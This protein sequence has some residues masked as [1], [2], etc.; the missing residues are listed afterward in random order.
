MSTFTL[1]ISFLTTFNLPWFMDQ[2]LHSRFLCNIALESIRLYFHHQS[3]LQLGIVFALVPSL[4]FFLELFLH[5]YPVPYRALTDLGI[6]S[7]SVL[8]FHLFILFMG[9][10]WQEYRSGLPFPSPVDH[11][12]SELSTTIH[13]YWVVIICL[14]NAC[15]PYHTSPK[16]QVLKYS[17]KRVKL[18]LCV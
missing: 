3:H 13:P 9:F 8:Y 5:W 11:V 1:A 14:I 7:F 17:F 15:F 6:S 12:L 10:S 18:Y 2:V 16:T 4:H